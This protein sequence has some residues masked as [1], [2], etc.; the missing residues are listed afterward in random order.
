MAC[1][2]NM[3]NN[4]QGETPSYKYFMT[5]HTKRLRICIA[6]A[7]NIAENSFDKV[8]AAAVMCDCVCVRIF[9]K[10]ISTY[11]KH[12]SNSKLHDYKRSFTCFFFIATGCINVFSAAIIRCEENSTEIGWPNVHV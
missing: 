1:T 12:R 2:E 5:L 8:L 10:K 7:H 11:E 4:S 3:S 9:S 6:A